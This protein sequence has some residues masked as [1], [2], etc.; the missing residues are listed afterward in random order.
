MLLKNW[1]SAGAMFAPRGSGKK[2]VPATFSFHSAFEL[3]KRETDGAPERRSIEVRTVAF[4]P[5]EPRSKL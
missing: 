3:S 4:I 1:D 2:T 5:D